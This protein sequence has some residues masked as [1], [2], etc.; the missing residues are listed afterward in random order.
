MSLPVPPE[1]LPAT[2]YDHPV[3]AA[4]LGE[5]L[6]L[7]GDGIAAA[8]IEFAA[9]DAGL[10]TGPL[11]I[12]DSMSI[13]PVDRAVH[14]S[15]YKQGGT[16]HH[17]HAHGTGGQH[18]HGHSHHHGHAHSTA[19]SA[20]H[21][22]CCGHTHVENSKW[23][24]ES[25]VYVVEKMSHGFKRLGRVSGGGFYDYGTQPPQLWSGLKSFE[26][27][28]RQLPAA[29]V[30]D[31]LLY[32]AIL[33]GL[34]SEPAEQPPAAFKMLFGAAVPLDA[35]AADAVVHSI[36]AS[37]FVARMSALA[38]RFGPRFGVTRDALARLGVA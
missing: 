22:E 36:G 2:L 28:S 25:A 7:L 29:D 5:S 24:P 6:A 37:T 19:G 21:S 38:A 23:L 12:L 15:Q 8:S 1:S 35:R 14:A 10:A 9:I 26:R 27:R 33:A 11:A 20:P 31:R 30:R 16:H 18:D 32:A 34:E 4:L 17:H 13:D 3:I